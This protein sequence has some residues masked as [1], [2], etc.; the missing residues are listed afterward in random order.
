MRD[1]FGGVF[2]I[3]LLLVFIFIY[4]AFTAISLTYAKAFKIKNKV[5]DFVE[6]NEIITLEDSYL[7]SKL[8]QLDDIIASANYNVSCEDLTTTN[9]EVK[10]SMGNVIGY[11]YRGIKITILEDNQ[12]KGTTTSKI[13]Y[14]ITTGATWNLGALNKILVLGGEQ[15]NSRGTVLGTWKI[16]GEAVVVN[17]N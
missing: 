17:N 1:S 15:E 3:N 5:I 12:I 8:S 9:G 14:Q 16:T 10:D 2:T 13:K 4:V 7:S 11:C 6:Q